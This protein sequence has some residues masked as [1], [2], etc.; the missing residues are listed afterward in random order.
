MSGGPNLAAKAER[1]SRSKARGEPM[2]EFYSDSS[3]LSLDLNKQYNV[4]IDGMTLRTILKALA[5]ARRMYHRAGM[6]GMAEE[7]AAARKILFKAREAP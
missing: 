5:D 4:G 2:L 7:A 6:T 3:T 1:N